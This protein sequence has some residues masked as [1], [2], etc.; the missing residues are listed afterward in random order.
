MES[1]RQKITGNFWKENIGFLCSVPVFLL[2]LVLISFLYE[3]RTEFVFYIG[4][5]YCILSGLALGVQYSRFRRLRAEREELL[6]QEH[7]GHEQEHKAWEELQEKQDFFSLWAHQIKTPIS[8]L[9]L[10]LQGEQPDSVSCRQELF[11]I[12][13]YVEMALNYMRFEDMR[14]DLVLERYSLEDL[15]RQVVKKYATIFIYNHISIELKELQ[16]QVLTDEKWFC[17]VLEQVLS[18]AL[19]YTRQGS[20]TIFAKETE[21]GICLVV[22]DTGIGIRSEDLPRIFEKGFTG[23]N[24]RVDRKASGLGLY[25]CKGICGKLGHRIYVTSRP[26]EGTEVNLLLPFENVI[27]KDLNK[28]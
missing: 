12:E 21:Q 7:T 15:V 10:L 28:S 20:V 5:L 9:N 18:N 13:N 11:K 4:A 27:R 2:L 1:K 19:K 3:I 14:N 6:Q 24:G 26:G 17:F 22:K 8:A 25:L 16:Y 23:Y